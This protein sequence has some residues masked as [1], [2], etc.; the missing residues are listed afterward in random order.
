MVVAIILGLKYEK[1]IRELPGIIIDLYKIYLFCKSF[2]SIETIRIV[3]D[4][5]VEESVT[6]LSSPALTGIV[7]PG[8]I[9]FI[10]DRKK[11]DTLLEYK[12]EEDFRGILSVY[13]SEEDKVMFYYTGHGIRN[14]IQLPK[15]EFLKYTDL[16]NLI[17]KTIEP[18]AECLIIL[19]CC[20]CN[21]LSFPFILEDQNWKLIHD[22]DFTTINCVLITSTQEQEESNASVDGSVFTTS[23]MDIFHQAQDLN[24]VSIKDYLINQVNE[25]LAK[26]DED[27]TVKKQTVNLYCTKPHIHE[28]WKWLLGVPVLNVELDSNNILVVGREI[29][30]KEKLIYTDYCIIKVD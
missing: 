20:H 18:R 16:K 17:F 5:T 26:N 3:S 8:I 13:Y 30:E 11:D 1:E 22:T 9:S 19:D 29:K 24:W 12:S 2:G 21:D 14:G 28:L 4:I 6:T 7:S 10:G 15:H 27:T 23:L 25:K